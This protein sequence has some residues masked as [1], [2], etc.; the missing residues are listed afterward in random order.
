M[1]RLSGQAAHEQ[2]TVVRALLQ[3]PLLLRRGRHTHTLDLARRHQAELRAWFDHHLGWR[4]HIERDRL[5]LFKTP[6]STDP[7]GHLAPTARQCALYCLILAV[8]GECGKQTVLS[9]LAEKITALTGAHGR[10]RRFDATHHRERVDLVAMVRLLTEQGVLATVGGEST[11][12]RSQEKEYISGT[13]DALYDVDH[14]T[15]ALLL[16]SPVP[17]AQADGPQAL[18]DALEPARA[19]TLDEGLRHALTRR[20]V[21]DPAVHWD[22]LPAQQRDFARARA[23]ALITAVRLG[24]DTRVEVRTEGAAVIDDELSD[25]EFPKASA[26]SFATLALADLLCTRIDSSH[27]RRPYVSHTQLHDLAAQLSEQLGQLIPNINGQPISATRVLDAC[28]PL[29]LQLGLVAHAPGGIQCRPVL[30]RF[31]APAGQGLRPEGEELMLFGAHDLPQ[32]TTSEE[33]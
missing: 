30:A 24:L 23:D 8:L 3:Q 6:A 25:I 20:L 19:D 2:S 18:A 9:E 11:T 27:P 32:P 13:G 28:L 15:A 12:T 10:L 5:R 7:Q 1:N 16:A 17:P 14:R 4:L 33:S 21:D 29:L 22:D 31:R 26:A